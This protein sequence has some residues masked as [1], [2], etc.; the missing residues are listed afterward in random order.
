MWSEVWCARTRRPHVAVRVHS[1]E[2]LIFIM[3]R[4]PPRST[5]TDTLCPY[6]T[7]VRTPRGRRRGGPR[8]ADPPRALHLWHRRA[9]APRRAVRQRSGA[10]R[11]ARLPVHRPRLSRRSARTRAVARRARRGLLPGPP[12]PAEHPI[13]SA[14]CKDRGLQYV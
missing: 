12:T 14:S 5:R 7:L 1:I 13:G 9:R 4:P 6:T 2:R 8:P 10:A 3:I 11:A